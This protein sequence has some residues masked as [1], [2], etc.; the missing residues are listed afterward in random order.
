[1]RAERTAKCAAGADASGGHFEDTIGELRASLPN[2][3]WHIRMA[4]G[5][6]ITIDSATMMNKGSSLERLALRNAPDQIDVV[7]H[8]Q[9]TIHSMWST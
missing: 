8:P 2:R 3:R 4:H 6:R 9:S 1:L 7:I 5:N